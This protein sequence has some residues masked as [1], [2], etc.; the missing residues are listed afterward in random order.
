M[1]TTDERRH[2]TVRVAPE[3]LNDVDRALLEARANGHLPM[4]YNRSDALRDL[5]RQV[6]EDPSVLSDY[7]PN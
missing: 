5:M 6:A 3:L 4:N 7:D 1:A 2:V